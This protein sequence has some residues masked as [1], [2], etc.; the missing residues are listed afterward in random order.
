MSGEPLRCGRISYTNDLPIY[1]AFDAG[2]VECPATLISGVPTQLNR[3]L[4]DGDLDVS[5][6][7]SFFCAEHA[8][9]LL[10]LPGVCIGSRKAVRS[11]YCISKTPP[12]SLAGVPIAVTAESSTGRNLFATVC[13]ERY[14]FKPLYEEAENPFEA[15]RKNGSPCLLIGDK[16]IDSYLAAHRDDAYDVGELWH[17]LTGLQMV[18]AVWAVR[19]DVAERR[20]AEVDALSRSLV[21][22][23]AWGMANLDRVV[24]EAQADVARPDGF[25]SEYYRTLDFDFNEN[26]RVGFEKFC[27]LAAKHG[28]LANAPELKTFTKDLAR[29]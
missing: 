13:A 4:V 28:L 24:A 23:A 17:E 12:R 10:V 19:R 16:A 6:I 27:S 14:G 8:G 1:A 11:I 9:D 22:A 7:S 18:Y 15:Y 5:P 3:M 26:A 25:Y 2:A 20:A 21:D 29:V